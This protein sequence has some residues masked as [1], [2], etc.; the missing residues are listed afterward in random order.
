MFQAF[1]GADLEKSR[2]SPQ[3]QTHILTDIQQHQHRFNLPQNIPNHPQFGRQQHSLSPIPNQQQQQ[4]LYHQH[5]RN[6]LLPINH[7]PQLQPQP[8]QDQLF[9]NNHQQFALLPT[10]PV[11]FPTGGS[12]IQGAGNQQGVLSIQSSSNPLATQNFG[13][14]PT[15]T[16]EQQK[17]RLQQL[18]DKQ[19][20]IDK[21]NQYVEK[22][23]EKALKKA[24]TDHVVFVEEQGNKKKK[25]YQQVFKP[26]GTPAVKYSLNNPRYPYPEEQHLFAKSLE[27]Y[28]L[29]HPTTTTTTTTT[30]PPPTTQATTTEDDIGIQAST[31]GLYNQVRVVTDGGQRVSFLP[32]ALPTNTRLPTIQ[33]LEDLKA[34]KQKY[35]NQQINKDDLLAQLKAAIGDPEDA[36]GRNETSREISLANGQKVQIIKT[37]DPNLIPGVATR[38]DGEA[39]LQKLLS[40]SST[41]TFKPPTQYLEELTKGVLPPGSNF[42]LLKHSANGGLEQVGGLPSSLPNQKKV[43]FVLLEEQSDGSFKV[44]GVKGNNNKESSEVDVDSILNRIKNGEIKLPPPVNRASP[45][46]PSTSASPPTS[47]ASPTTADNRKYT[48]D[49]PA[50]SVTVFPNSFASSPSTASKIS[51]TL[52]SAAHST[53]P[54]SIATTSI[55]RVTY[56]E[57]PSSREDVFFRETSTASSPKR[58]SIA[59]PFENVTSS[60]FLQLENSNN[61][62]VY[63]ELPDVLKANELYAMAKFLKQSGLDTILNETGPYTVFA[64]TDKAFRNLLIQLGGPEKAEE[65]FKENPRLLS[66]V[67]FQG[68]W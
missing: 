48:Q 26:P 28:Y 11:V 36:L 6:Q 46:T 27:Q 33:S 62:N 23:Y 2:L 5:I 29:E 66:G 45:S 63:V 47:P 30:P 8:P 40:V 54:R 31:S 39:S 67:S 4:S 52:T 57:K 17:Q 19:A 7:H 14:D 32:T 50:A 68:A 56:N 3:Q 37:T 1:G 55:P 34:L 65:K 24:Q 41:T 22:Q 12:L 42:E 61:Q 35:K 44:Q 38:Y 25:L 10:Q 21:H 60:E 16:P 58:N 20:I 59:V 15:L 13:I 9:P 53:T 18:K 51:F 64:P 43:T 49:V